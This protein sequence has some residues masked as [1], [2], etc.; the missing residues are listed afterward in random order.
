MIY[1][2]MQCF[3]PVRKEWNVMV[4]RKRG[5]VLREVLV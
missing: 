4:L 5:L 2:K 3:I 1:G